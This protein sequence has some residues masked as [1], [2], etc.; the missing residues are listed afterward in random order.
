MSYYSLTALYKKTENI[1]RIDIASY[2]ILNYKI[3]KSVKFW[4]GF[5]MVDKRRTN[6][7]FPLLSHLCT[8]IEYIFHEDFVR[9]SN[10]IIFSALRKPSNN[11]QVV[12]WAIPCF[13]LISTKESPYNWAVSNFLQ[14]R[15]LIW[16]YFY[17]IN[18]LIFSTQ[19]YNVSRV[20]YRY[21][22]LVIR[23]LQK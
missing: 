15:A 4:G 20:N 5:C 19:P 11:L 16:H 7:L 21:Q 6:K 23:P 22:A 13:F 10:K 8:K 1:V 9:K 3:F 12:K 14:L 18:I 17:P 2:K